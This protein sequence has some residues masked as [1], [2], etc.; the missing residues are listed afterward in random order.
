MLKILKT[1]LF[2]GLF[3]FLIFG[4][5]SCN[6]TS[7]SKTVKGSYIELLEKD[8]SFECGVNASIPVAIVKDENGEGVSHD[9]VCNKVID[10]DGNSIDID[11]DSFTPRQ[12]GDY[13]LIYK[14]DNITKNFVISCNDTIK[15]VIN[16]TVEEEYAVAN[17][18]EDYVSGIYKVHEIPLY[19]VTD[20]SGV[21]A[22]KTSLKVFLNGKERQIDRENS[23][24]TLNESGQIRF[25]ITARDENGLTNTVNYESEA[26]VPENFPLYCLSSF[27]AKNY[28]KLVGGGWLGSPF[29]SSILDSYTDVNGDSYEGVLKVDYPATNQEAG[30]AV[31][32]GRNVKV[33]EIDYI[34]V[35]LCAKNLSFESSGA[36]NVIVYKKSPFWENSNL[37][38]KIEENVWTTLRLPASLIQNF[39]DLDGDTVS[40]FAIETMDYSKEG[41]TVYLA[42]ISYGYNAS[43]LSISEVS[44]NTT[45]INIVTDANFDEMENGSYITTGTLKKN[46]EKIWLLLSKN[47]MK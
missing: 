18:Y 36:Y 47:K 7:K 23:T 34:S 13:I 30:L 3:T 2:A 15:P 24:F 14:Y 45:S 25:E 6:K 12:V 32:L 1:I 26:I 35:T 44:G 31:T 33:S 19:K 4:C 28:R 40:G 8:Y 10:P 11:A 43:N 29:T 38:V 22:A 17:S 16:A 37:S 9:A 21:F 5:M 20:L 27:S 39:T 42:D 41:R 46:E